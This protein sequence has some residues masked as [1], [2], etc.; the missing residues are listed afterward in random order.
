MAEAMI[1]A[2]MSAEQ[3]SQFFKQCLDIPFDAKQADLSTRKMNQFQAL[4][5]AYSA[6]VQEGTKPLSQWAALNAITRYV[7]HDKTTRG[8]DNKDEARVLSANFGSGAA[9][10]AKAVALLM[11]DLSKMLVAA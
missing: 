1:A 8:S 3:V 4:R 11:P 2:D 10:K 6:T 7:D 5:N 9:L